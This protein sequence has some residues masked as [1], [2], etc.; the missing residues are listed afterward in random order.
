MYTVAGKTF[1]Y[2]MTLTFDLRVNICQET[3]VHEMSTDSSSHFPVQ[4]RQ[5]N[6]QTDEVKNATNHTL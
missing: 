4:H 2:H 3:A 6:T 5:T 1:Y